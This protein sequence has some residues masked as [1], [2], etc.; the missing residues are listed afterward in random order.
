MTGAANGTLT[1]QVDGSWTYTPDPDWNG[2]EALAYDISD[3]NGGTASA[4]ATVTVTAVNDAPVAGPDAYATTTLAVLNVNAA[5]GVLS[6]DSDVDG[7][8]LIVTGDD[9][10]TVDI[11]PDG[12]FTYVPVLPTTEVVNYTVSDGNG[13]TATGTMTITV[14]LLPTSIIQLFMQPVG[15]YTTGSLTTTPP[16]NGIAD[17]DLDGNPGLTIKSSDMKATET[18]PLKYQEWSYPVPAGDVVMN[19]PITMDLWTSL[20]NQANHDLDYASWVYD[21]NGF[22]G[23]SLIASTVNV[24]VNNWS[25]TTTWEK[26]TVTVGSANRTVLA[27]HTI[28]VRIAFNHTDVWLPLDSAHPSSL[29]YTD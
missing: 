28:K 5:N 20:K 17:Y 4:N 19:G 21:C 16:L 24:H 29:N 14:T 12:S 8:T 13:G 15:T 7:D 11:N 23:C 9:S 25:T 22:F 2:T 27:G 26:R 10:P 1:Q 6:N 18:D 3:G